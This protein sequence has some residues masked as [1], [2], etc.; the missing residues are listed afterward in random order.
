VSLA[1]GGGFG[2][3][4]SLGLMPAAPITSNGTAVNPKSKRG[5]RKRALLSAPIMFS[6]HD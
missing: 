4:S 2:G 5:A 6:L 1:G 3:E